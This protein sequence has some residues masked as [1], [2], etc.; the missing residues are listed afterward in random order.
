MGPSSGSNKTK[1]S[2]GLSTHPA[3]ND[4]QGTRSYKSK[5][6]IVNCPARS[7]VRDREGRVM[8]SAIAKQCASLGSQG[9]GGVTTGRHYCRQRAILRRVGTSRGSPV[10][11]YAAWGMGRSAPS[12]PENQAV[13]VPQCW[14]GT[15]LMPLLRAL[16]TLSQLVRT[17]RHQVSH[18]VINPDICVRQTE[19]PQSLKLSCVS[20]CRKR[21]ALLLP[22]KQSFI[23]QGSRG[24]LS[25][26]GKKRKEKQRG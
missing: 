15:R 11:Q 4:K 6:A 24:G 8:G 13:L 10:W 26:I 1:N 7:R 5:G 3:L 14:Q 19:L 12:P 20:I 17:G 23:V 25:L 9:S 16:A 22:K 21:E 18:G 2:S